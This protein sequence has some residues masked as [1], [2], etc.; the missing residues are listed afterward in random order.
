MRQFK[1]NVT[2]DK[3]RPI[4]LAWCRAYK[5]TDNTEV[6]TQYTDASGNAT[7]SALTDNV[8]CYILALW[9]NQGKRFFS[10]A[11]IGTTEIDDL[12]VTTAKINDCTVNKL[13]TGTLTATITNSGT[14]QTAA[15][16]ARVVIDSTG[17]KSY[18]STGYQRAQIL[19]DGSGFFGDSTSL[20]WDISGNVTASSITV[21]SSSSTAKV[22]LDNNGLASYNS[23]GTQCCKIDDDGSGWFGSTTAFAWTTAGVITCTGITIQSAASPSARVVIDPSYIAG[24]SD[25]TTKQFYL[26]AS[27]GKAYFAGG[28]AVVSSL[29][30]GFLGTGEYLYWTNNSNT[31]Y[32]SYSGVTKCLYLSAG[33]SASGTINIAGGLEIQ[34]NIASHLLFGTADTYDIGDATNRVRRLFA[35]GITTG[36]GGSSMESVLMSVY[37][38]IPKKTTTGNPTG[39]AAQDGSIYINTYDKAVRIYAGA[40]WR[41]IITWA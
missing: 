17:I 31:G 8:D 6:E 12:A 25:A 39:D 40:A 11:T 15:S 28:N 35:K 7:F 33:V 30:L 16:G 38:R 19:N 26:Q 9:G 34:G 1:I 21:R 3:G 14:I 23:T 37:L 5:S 20:I 24:Y 13:T 10:E 36:E 2:N 22:L 4:A 18:A 27:D 41:D 32:I 29:G